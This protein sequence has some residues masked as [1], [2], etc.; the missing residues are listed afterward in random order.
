MRVKSPLVEH[1]LTSLARAQGGIAH[2]PD[3]GWARRSLHFSWPRSCRP[4][5]LGDMRWNVG[6][7][8][9]NLRDGWPRRISTCPTPCNGMQAPHLPLWGCRGGAMS[10]VDVVR[11]VAVLNGWFLSQRRDR[12]PASPDLRCVN[13]RY[14]GLS[15][16]TVSMSPFL[17]SFPRTAP[18]RCILSHFRLKQ[19]PPSTC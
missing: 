13:S 19:H 16:R 8:H 17:N 7:G 2:Q 18:G 14:N 12:S 3:L 10:A 9:P 4:F 11:C 1:Q 15:D 5:V 6:L